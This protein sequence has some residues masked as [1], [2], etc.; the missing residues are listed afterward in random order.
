MGVGVHENQVCVCVWGRQG[1]MGVGVCVC[2]CVC[3][4]GGGGSFT[5]VPCTYA[6]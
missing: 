4:R 3:V 1:Y 5:C 6:S 2:V